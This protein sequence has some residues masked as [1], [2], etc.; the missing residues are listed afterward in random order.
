MKKIGWKWWVVIVIAAIWFL[1]NLEFS[2]EGA[3]SDEPYFRIK[4]VELPEGAEPVSLADRYADLG[5]IGPANCAA[6]WRALFADVRTF[7]SGAGA[8]QWW[9]LAAPFILVALLLLPL[10]KGGNIFYSL[11]DVLRDL[12]HVEQGDPESEK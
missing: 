8:M 9:G 6:S 7:V 11:R 3:A 10:C 5:W 4:R 1:S 2:R 12:P